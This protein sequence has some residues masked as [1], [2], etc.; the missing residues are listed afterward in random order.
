MSEISVNNVS[1]YQSGKFPF[2]SDDID[3]KLKNEEWGLK[4][5]EAIYSMYVTDRCGIPFSKIAEMQELRKYGAGT[6]DVAK[7]QKI[8][9]S[10]N[11]KG[12]LEGFLNVNWDIFSVMP[13][14]KH[15]IQGIFEEQEHSIVATAIDQKSIEDK[16]AVILRKWFK[17]RYK[18]V[19]N[20]IRQLGGYEPLDEWLPETA[21]EL[22]I[23]QTMGGIKLA[24]ETAIE[25]ALNY[26]LYISD[27]KEVKRKIIDDLVDLGCAAVKDYTDQYTR[28]AKIRYVDPVNLIIQYSRHWDHRNSE[29]A[30]EIISES[31]SNLRKNTN[32]SE[33][34]LRGIA[35]AFNGVMGNPVINSWNTED[36]LM[37]GGTY[38]YDEF[39]IPVL[40]AEWFS[41]NSRYRTTR[42]NERGEEFTYDSEWGKVYNKP[43]RKTEIH[44]YKTVYRCKWIIGT[45]F[46]YDFGI[47]YDI[48]RPGKK[49]VELSFKFYKISG[50]SMVSL[51]IPNLDQIQLTWLKLQ[52]ALAMSSNAGIAVEYTSLQNMKLGGE[53]MEPIDILALRRDTGDLIY[54]LTTHT[55]R[56]NVPGGMR[57]VQELQ[58]GIGPQL[59]E[60]IQLFE[61]NLNFIR[62]LTGINQIA[63]AST[64]DPNQSVGGSKLAVAQTIK[65]LRPIYSGYIRLKELVCRSCAI[66]I[67]NIVGVDSEAYK[68]YIPAI[69]QGGVK[70]LDFDSENIDA[71][72]HIKIE[73]KPT[74]ERKQIILQAAMNAMQPDR[75][76]YVGIQMEDFLLI[77]RMLEDGNLKF[78]E[79][80]LSYRSQQNKERQLR[81][82]R[83]NMMLDAQN[84]QQTAMLKEQ[85]ARKT[86]QFET[87]E[88]IRLEMAKADL[89][90][91]NNQREFERKLQLSLSEKEKN[92]LTNK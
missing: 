2:P 34:Q 43:N 6:Q 41:I 84:A 47:Q 75:D 26:T 67:Q 83:E 8:L 55:G 14:F 53:K 64:P 7:Y 49:E 62:E 70:L 38:I 1:T 81:L 54:K 88:A 27:W 17:A 85:E 65:A 51:A 80:Y 35:R 74:E 44:K 12:E 57:P 72:Y 58:G 77:L 59:N 92:T 91:R 86:K 60:F 89:E 40:D 90:D 21:H 31:I 32:L 66:R 76:G 19:I 37:S 15:I 9:L 52:N 16:Q 61:L 20:E 39:H 10:E 63:D 56:P 45:N 71:D 36:L 48:P 33:E 25:E 79:Y 69:G 50:R 29:Y 18:D 68:I 11:E 3:P 82:Q 78:A 28:K 4:F 24:K 5:C 87:D 13:K 30:G 23:Y 46:V 73:A 42:I 22:Q